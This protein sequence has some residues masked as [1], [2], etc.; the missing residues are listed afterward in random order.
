MIAEKNT[1]K[2]NNLNHSKTK[3]YLEGDPL[4]M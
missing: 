1:Q 2:K 4:P 3:S